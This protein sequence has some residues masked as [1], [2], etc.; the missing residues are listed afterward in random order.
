MK[1]PGAQSL[2]GFLLKSHQREPGPAAKGAFCWLFALL[3]LGASGC[4]SAP[5]KLAPSVTGPAAGAGTYH[6]VGS[7]Q[8]L[9]RIA[10]TYNV[11]VNELMRVNGIS[12][13]GQLGVGQKLFIPR[14]AG[15][16]VIN[17][18]RGA[19]AGD[20]EN[21]VGPRHYSSH[22]KTI[23]LHHS[24]TLGGNAGSFDRNHRR[25]G[26]GGLFYHFVI[27]NGTGSGDGEIEVGWRWRKQAQVNRPDDIQICLVGDFN[28]QYV[29]PRQFEALT[30]LIT[31]LRRQYNIPV[32][33]IRRHK[34]I[35]GKH[36]ACPGRDFPFDRLISRLHN[37]G[38]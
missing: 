9:W 21:I 12:D 10:K 25:R 23:T 32:R 7:G 34:S 19:A 29:S 5:H 28:R 24:G 6:I 33:N 27:G 4:V 30:A 13:P 8:T 17:P 22:W 26:M 14:A 38:P 3:V 18:A 15:T 11:E 20:V 2:F 36:T 16:I 1:Y 31:V 35:K 37:T